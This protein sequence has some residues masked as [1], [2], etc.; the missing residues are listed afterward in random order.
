MDGVF[1]DPIFVVQLQISCGLKASE[2]SLD[3]FQQVFLL[4]LASNVVNVYEGTQTSLQKALQK[5]LRDTLP[6]I[7]WELVWGPVVW[8]NKPDEDTTGP[9][10]A[11]YVARH[12]KLKLD[13]GSVR[14]TYV[15]A[16]A[17]TPPKSQYAW[18]QENFAV[19]SV[20]DFNVWVAGGIQNPP[21]VVPAT[22]IQ[23]NTPYIATGIVN[24][25]QLLLT[26]KAPEGAMSEGNTL[27]DFI[28]NRSGNDRFIATGHSLG[29]ALSSSLALSL[30]SAGVI[31]ADS[32]LTYPSAAPSPGNKPFTDLFVQTF[33]A[34]KLDSAGTYQGWNLNLVNTLDI[35]PQAWSVRTLISPK[36]NLYNI[37]PIYGRPVLPFVKGIAHVFAVHTLRSGTL[38]FPLPSQYFTRAPPFTPPKTLLEFLGLAVPEHQQAYFDEVGVTVPTLDKSGDDGLRSK[39]EEE[40][41]FDYPIIAGFEWAREHPKEAEKEIENVEDSDEGKA[42]LNDNAV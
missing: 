25:V 6:S 31:S 22:A 40:I 15:I 32:T 33:P 10:N 41:L 27:L 16:I 26:T 42:C 2:M 3:V 21:V 24:A 1:K 4:S 19:N 13:D 18:S 11:W 34:R 29:G 20:S 37:P 36:Q 7:G 8:K 23:Q 38:Y 30:V 9:D 39:T 28:T 5:V 17:G 14:S 35:V 12:P